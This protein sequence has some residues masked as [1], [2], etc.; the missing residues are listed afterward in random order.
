VLLSIKICPHLHFEIINI[1][2][3]GILVVILILYEISSR[4]DSLFFYR[5]RGEKYAEWTLPRW[6]FF[7]LIF[8]SSDFLVQVSS[9]FLTPWRVQF[10]YE[11]S[12]N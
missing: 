11:V 2:K 6:Y 4:S 9:L 8:I 1:V 5:G 12:E 10:D 3:K 7:I